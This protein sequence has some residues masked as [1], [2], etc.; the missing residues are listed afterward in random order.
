MKL[1]ATPKR[2]RILAGLL[3][4]SA[5]AGS[6]TFANSII[7]GGYVSEVR[8]LTVTPIAA[9]EGFRTDGPIEVAILEIDNNLPD[10]EVVLDFSDRIGMA[11]AISEVRL[12]GLEGTLGQGLENP[13]S[14]AMR[15]GSL[16]G[17][18]IWSP[19][20]QTT[21]TLGY[22]MKVLVTF[23]NPPAA[24]PTMRVAMPAYF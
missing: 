23:V 10:F 16:P 6:H 19:G 9:E 20:R 14:I 24:P 15:P 12:V 7:A 8:N 2:F 1:T 11:D 22:R 17:R 21:A 3:L 4:L 13:G 18:F 5:S